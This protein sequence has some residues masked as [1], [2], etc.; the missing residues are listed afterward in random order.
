MNFYWKIEA[1]NDEGIR[2]QFEGWLNG[3]LKRQSSHPVWTPSRV[4]WDEDWSLEAV[5]VQTGDLLETLCPKDLIRRI[6][7]REALIQRSKEDPLRFL[8]E[9]PEYRRID[10]E[11]AR[12]R[13]AMPGVP[14]M[15]WVSGG[16]RSSKTEFVTRRVASNF[17]WTPRAWCWGFHQ[18]DTTSRSIQQARVYR[19]LPPEVRP[20][21][22]KLRKDRTTK[23]SYSEGTG[24][25][26]S[27]FNIYWE[28]RNEIE[29]EYTGGGMFEF[30]FY[31]QDAGTMVGQELTCATEDE[32]VPPQVVK[33][34]DDRLLTRAGDTR[35]RKFLQRIQHAIELLEAGKSLPPSLLAAVYHGW[36]LISFTP[37]EGWTPST[38]M[39]MQ[40][41]TEY[42][43]YDPTPQVQL[44]MQEA[45]AAMPTPEL[46]QAKAAELSANPWTLA[47]ITS[48]PAFAQPVDPRKLVA[49][50]PTFVNVFKGNW[51]GA[52]ESV[53]GRSRE[54]IEITLFGLVRRNVQSLLPYDAARHK[55]TEQEL[56]SS[57]TVFEVADPAPKK[58]WVIKWYM[59][60][61]A[62]RKQIVQEWPCETWEIEGVGL[63]G[64]WAVP[65]ESDKL[66]GDPGPAQ[67]LIL[68]RSWD[69][70]TRRIWQGRQRLAKRLRA[71][72][73][74]RLKVK[75]VELNL[76]WKNRPDWTLEGEFVAVAES[77]MD[78]RF[79]SLPT[80]SKGGQNSTAME[81]MMDAENRIIWDQAD[82][83]SIEDGVMLIQA[84][85]DAD[86]LGVPG[87]TVQAE[88]TNSIFALNTYAFP[89][90]SE[91]TK[92]KDEACKDYID[93]DRYFLKKDPIDFQTIDYAK[94]PQSFG[95]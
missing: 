67:Q 9:P 36:Q 66:N 30:R 56:W 6:A 38:S 74:D 43:H 44:A 34:V 14:L 55:R 71:V 91:N 75:T 78:S 17:W 20:D 88:C 60:D 19:F 5:P 68:P 84:E 80:T 28:C 3:Q 81:E 77:Y 89:E 94:L 45:I 90:Y 58:P 95:Y 72:H 21:S 73:G 24:F 93:P 4:L 26:G 48:V 2:K 87:F 27:Q 52:V 40:G 83:G 12:K 35:D 7:A 79:A 64:P 18:T 42:A 32:L 23:F 16:I 49:F 15:L 65:S 92:K 22:G 11:C 62:C 85:M 59:V 33:L 41:A 63:P 76:S 70:Y 51:P 10:L 53:Q 8:C 82:G 61:A 25:T 39:F 50:L 31:G 13:R 29:E 54:T 86:I 46:Q 47:G 69:D 1:M 57:G 37:K